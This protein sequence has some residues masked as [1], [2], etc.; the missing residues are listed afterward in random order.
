VDIVKKAT[1]YIYCSA[2][3]YTLNT[4]IISIEILSSPHVFI[5]N[6]ESILDYELW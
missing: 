6:N 1:D 4:G 5:A 2:S 3:N